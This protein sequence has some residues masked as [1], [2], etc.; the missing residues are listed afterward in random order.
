MGKYSTANGYA[1]ATSNGLDFV[2]N[3]NK[4]G[5]TS[6]TRIEFLR[7]LEAKM[8]IPVQLSLDVEGPVAETQTPSVDLAQSVLTACGGDPLLA[9]RELLADADFLREQL[10]T[11]SYM[12][13]SGMGR[14]WRP[15][16]ERT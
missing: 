13:S 9:I 7:D 3:E 12:M 14:G 2:S 5:T 4:I 10:V 6:L 1:V 16:Y 11:A 8:S 15:Q